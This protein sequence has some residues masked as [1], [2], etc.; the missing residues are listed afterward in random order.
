[1]LKLLKNLT[2]YL[3]LIL[4][5]QNMIKINFYYYLYFLLIYFSNPVK[6]KLRCQ[7]FIPL[8]YDYYQDKI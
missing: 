8:Q 6:Q 3:K 7:T 1:M 2:V 5:N 4:S